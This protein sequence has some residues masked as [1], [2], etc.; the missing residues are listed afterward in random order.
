MSRKFLFSLTIVLLAVFIVSLAACKGEKTKEHTN[1]PVTQAVEKPVAQATYTLI[2]T[3]IVVPVP[4]ATDTPTVPPTLPPLPGSVAILVVDDFTIEITP[5]NGETPVPTLPKEITDPADNCV[6]TLDGQR[7]FGS[8]GAQGFGSSG[9]GGISSTGVIT[10]VL[11]ENG[12]PIPH[13][14][15][16]YNHIRNDLNSYVGRQETPIPVLKFPT[17]IPVNGLTIF[18]PDENWK[19]ANDYTIYLVPVDTSH[20][21]TSAVINQIDATIAYIS[22][23]YPVQYFVLNMSFVIMPCDLG[24]DSKG[25]TIETN[26]L[27]D[28]YLDAL[29]D[30]PE[31]KALRDKLTEWASEGNPDDTK[32]N[33]MLYGPEFGPARLLY[34]HNPPTL[35]AWLEAGS[36]YDRI[37][38]DVLRQWLENPKNASSRRIISVAASGNNGNRG[39][40]YPFAP[41]IWDSVVSVS[42]SGWDPFDPDVIASGEDFD[43][44]APEGTYPSTKTYY[45]NPA[46]LTFN[47]QLNYS[48]PNPKNDFKYYFGT[49]YAAPRLSV[50]EAIHLL[51]GGDIR[52]YNDQ[53]TAVLSQPPLGYAD[54]HGPWDN[55]LIETAISTYCPEFRE[56]PTP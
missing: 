53:C 51:S 56:T 50:L 32:R 25:Y 54:D 33:S 3:T 15:L 2:P 46:E 41:A 9:A 13:G 24:K 19:I 30:I 34:F 36:N 39:Y 12:Q 21:T 28:G 40:E 47:G 16:V 10:Q 45:S 29:K 35:A 6:Y 48:I 20:Y 31:Y 7:G 23:K 27:I 5:V 18:E 1:V 11:D 52:C 14:Q 4:S 44:D 38:N 42:A 37:K 22:G 43:A 55:L 49:S 8:S 17:P 26:T